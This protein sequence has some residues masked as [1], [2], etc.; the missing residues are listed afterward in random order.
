[1][2]QEKGMSFKEFR[3]RLQTEEACEAYLFEQRWPDGFICPKC[4]GTG[5]YQLRG[6]REYACKHCSGIVELDDAYFGAPK[7]NGKRGRGTEKTSALAAVSLSEQGHH[8]MPL[9]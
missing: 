8:W 7:S 6:R 9:Q 3:Q 1:M 5:C 4:G 2:S